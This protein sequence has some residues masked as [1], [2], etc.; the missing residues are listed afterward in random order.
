MSR[1]GDAGAQLGLVV[2]RSPALA[3]GDS[4]GE[5]DRSGRVPLFGVELDEDAL[6][7][8]ALNSSVVLETR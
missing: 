5:R 6:A 1:V 7:K 2:A 4:T 8:Y 3:F